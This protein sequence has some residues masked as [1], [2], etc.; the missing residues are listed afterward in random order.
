MFYTPNSLALNDNRFDLDEHVKNTSTW[1]ANNCRDYKHFAV[2]TIAYLQWGLKR[3][4]FKIPLGDI[5]G[6]GLDL[7]SLWDEWE[8]E[9]RGD[10]RMFI[11]QKI[12]STGVSKF[13]YA[14]FIADCDAW[15]LALI[16]SSAPE[17][18]LSE[19]LRELYAQPPRILSLIHI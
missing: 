4:Y 18:R 14:D 19:A 1:G 11:R 15:L 17:K 3:E 10:F 5:G 9:P 8:K 7:L 2:S 16:L 12:G 13:G 6:W